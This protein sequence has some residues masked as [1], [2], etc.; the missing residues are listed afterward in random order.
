MTG[1][2]Q[3]QNL[4]NAVAPFPECLAQPDLEAP[5]LKIR[6]LEVYS[7]FYP[8]VKALMT[9]AEKVMGRAHLHPIIPIF[10]A[11]TYGI[12]DLAA[13]R[14]THPRHLFAR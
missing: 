5:D 7:D 9:L 14:Y 4:V 3:R 8:E 13:S 6:T 10:E 1:I 2:L 11:H 12:I